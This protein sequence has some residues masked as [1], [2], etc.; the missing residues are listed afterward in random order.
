MDLL[1]VYSTVEQV[2]CIKLFRKE[3]F[4]IIQHIEFNK[5]TRKKY[6]DLTI[7]YKLLIQ[8]SVL[9]SIPKAEKNF[10]DFARFLC[11]REY[12]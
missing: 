11:V 8:Q 10:D 7:H 4:V 6:D 3:Q 1:Y 9:I 12:R 5:V 2:T